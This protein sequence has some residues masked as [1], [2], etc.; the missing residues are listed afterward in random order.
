VTHVR[1][2]HDVRVTDYGVRPPRRFLGLLRVREQVTV[3][4]D[5]PLAASRPADPLAGLQR[6]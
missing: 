6:R 2:T 1:G 5:V 3:H 4:F